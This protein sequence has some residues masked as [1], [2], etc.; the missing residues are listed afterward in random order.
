MTELPLLLPHAF[1]L[2]ELKE[3]TGKSPLHQHVSSLAL[4]GAFLAELDFSGR[5]MNT[6][7]NLYAL[8]ANGESTGIMKRAEEKLPKRPFGQKKGVFALQR[9][10]RNSQLRPRVLEELVELGCL[11]MEVDRFLRIPYR[12]RWP[13]A[14]FSVENTVR[15]HLRSWVE[16]VTDE[17]PPHREDA[18]LS[19]LRV[20]DLYS[21]I[22]SEAELEALGPKLLERTKRAP[23]GKVVKQAIR[24]QEAALAAAAIAST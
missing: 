12:W 2:L 20:T 17:D 4:S 1:V 3:S 11:R 6:S 16:R 19:L 22:W 14:D 18:L 15:N 13:N 9:G 23:I 21:V 7:A 8:S 10:W 24:E 5:L